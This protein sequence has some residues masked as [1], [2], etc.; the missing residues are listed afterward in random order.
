MS[1]KMLENSPLR[2]F[3]SFVG[4][5]EKELADLIERTEGRPGKRIDPFGTDHGRR[6]KVCAGPY[7]VLYFQNLLFF[8]IKLKILLCIYIL[9]VSY[10][11]KYFYF[12]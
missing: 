4:M 6:T 1:L 10:I 2:S 5:D 12:F 8:L 3:K 11:K 9:Y 7:F